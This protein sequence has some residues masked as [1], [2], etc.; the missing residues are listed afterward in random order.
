MGALLP[1]FPYPSINVT[2]PAHDLAT[3]IAETIVRDRFEGRM[4]RVLDQSEIEEWAVAEITATSPLTVLDLR[5]TGLLRLGVST[6][7]ARA[8]NHWR[9]RQLSAAIH[10]A[11]AIDGLLYASRL[12]SAECVAVYDRAIEGKLGASPATNLVRHPDL[13]AALQS[14]GVSLRGGA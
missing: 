7:A 12:T 13:I 6:D 4:K 3:A 5:T 9:G 1:Q 11:F 14:I 2:P 8:K 10:G